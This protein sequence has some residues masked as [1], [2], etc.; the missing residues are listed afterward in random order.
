[1]L[2]AAGGGARRRRDLKRP[3]GEGRALSR[4]GGR[5]KVAPTGGIGTPRRARCPHRAADR[6]KPPSPRG[7]CPSAHTG[8]GG[9]GQRFS[10]SIPQSRRLRET[11]RDSPLDARGPRAGG[12]KGRPYEGGADAGSPGNARR[13]GRRRR[14]VRRAVE[15]ASPYRGERSI[16]ASRRVAARCFNFPK[17]TQMGYFQTERDMLYSEV[18]EH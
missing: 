6:R 11:R 15:G 2:G 14:S 9:Y 18:R 16:G 1:M 10:G 17:K 8:A 13:Y 7:G 3:Y 12:H 5:P 4:I